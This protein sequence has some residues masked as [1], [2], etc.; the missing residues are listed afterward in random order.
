[1]GGGGKADGGGPEGGLGTE[2]GP[3]PEGNGILGGS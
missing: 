3:G 2:D 1:M